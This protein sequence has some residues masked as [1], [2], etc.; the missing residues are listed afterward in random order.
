MGIY[1]VNFL[2]YSMAMVGLL[3][4]CLLV[5]KKTMG[6]NCGKKNSEDLTV[7]NAMNLSA[8]KT[9]YIVKAGDEKFLIASDAERT[10]FLAKLNDTQNT[11]TQ[12]ISD[13]RNF[14]SFS[15]NQKEFNIEKS[16]EE[17]YKEK[18]VDYTEVM[19]AINNTK[20]KQPVMKEILRKLDQQTKA[21][22]SAKE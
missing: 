11:I 18:G 5:Y 14:S 7:E 17:Q 9:L 20:H 10:T 3:F 1:L 2:V 21:V 22:E 19:N 8:R 6:N 12:Q 13:S 15:V 16:H 4:V